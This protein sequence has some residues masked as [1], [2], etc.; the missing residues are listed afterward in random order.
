MA[1]W[2]LILLVSGHRVRNRHGWLDE[3]A[4]NLVEPATRSLVFAADSV[5][6]R[7][8]TAPEPLHFQICKSR[9]PGDERETQQSFHRG[10]ESYGTR[11]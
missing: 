8:S 10:Y 11:W 1:L 7:L 2:I 9:G 3:V 4:T 5:N 6:Y